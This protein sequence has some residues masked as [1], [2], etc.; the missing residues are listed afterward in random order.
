MADRR[1]GSVFALFVRPEFESRGYGAALLEAAVD[2]LFAR[3]FEHVRLE[4]GPGT[5]AHRFYL[6]CGWI[7]VGTGTNG[8]VVMQ[9]NR[10]PERSWTPV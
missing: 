1:D 4:V 6:K 5:R 8:D 3:D 9:L 10:C 2:W 7:E